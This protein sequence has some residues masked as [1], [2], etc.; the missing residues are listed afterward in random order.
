MPFGLGVKLSLGKRFCL[1]AFWE[2]HKT[3]S[4]YIDDVSTTYYLQGPLINPEDKA[5]VLSDPSLNHQPGMQRGN[6]RNNDWYSFSGISLTYK[7][8]IRAGKRCKDL[9]H[10]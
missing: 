6:S 2:M 5:A 7:F 9:R 3:F 4:D 10:K 1:A 8:S